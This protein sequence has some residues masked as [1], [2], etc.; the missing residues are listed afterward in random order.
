[1]LIWL[2]YMNSINRHPLI[3]DRWNSTLHQAFSSTI[4]TRFISNLFSAK[5]FLFH[6]FEINFLLI[7]FVLK[8]MYNLKLSNLKE[9]RRI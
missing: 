7:L 2:V 3:D 6:D 9:K 4:L 5:L 1:M 8:T